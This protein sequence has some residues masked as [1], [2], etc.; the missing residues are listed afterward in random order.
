[1]YEPIDNPSQAVLPVLKYARGE[2]F[3]EKH[4]MEMYAML[5]IPQA[6]PVEKLT[7]GDVIKVRAIV[8][9]GCAVIGDYYALRETKLFLNGHFYYCIFTTMYLGCLKLPVL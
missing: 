4:W 9:Y 3:A 8:L 6:I 5:G 2:V 7:F 1:M